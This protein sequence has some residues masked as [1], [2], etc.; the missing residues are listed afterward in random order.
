VSSVSCPLYPSHESILTAL[1]GVDAKIHL[2]NDAK[3]SPGLSPLDPCRIRWQERCGTGPAGPGKPSRSHYRSYVGVLFAS[4][5]RNDVTGT[6]IPCPI[7]FLPLVHDERY[8]FCTG[9]SPGYQSGCKGMGEHG[10]S[11]FID[12]I[13]P[14]KISWDTARNCHSSLISRDRSQLH[15]A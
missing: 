10:S 9:H 2:G 7:A 13:Q 1:S 14:G 6:P 4:R 11:A 15:N 12:G 5:C 8:P 3:R